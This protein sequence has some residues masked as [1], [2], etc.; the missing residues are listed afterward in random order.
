[1]LSKNPNENFTREAKKPKL[2][3][4]SILSLIVGYYLKFRLKNTKME[5][6]AFKILTTKNSFIPIKDLFHEHERLSNHRR[7][8]VT[9]FENFDFS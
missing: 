9:T 8:K 6:K 2:T 5:T 1:M 7:K 3:L 4:I